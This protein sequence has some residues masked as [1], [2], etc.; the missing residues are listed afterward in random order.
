MKY[1]SKKGRIKKLTIEYL[2]KITPILFFTYNLSPPSLYSSW[3]K[4]GSRTGKL[5]TSINCAT[6]RRPV[7]K[8]I[9]RQETMLLVC[10]NPNAYANRLTISKVNNDVSM[11]SHCPVSFVLPVATVGEV[12][13]SIC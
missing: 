13:I 3:E 9:G 1:N 7:K 5:Y 4:G 10:R 8:E 2:R 12:S 11:Y 6:V